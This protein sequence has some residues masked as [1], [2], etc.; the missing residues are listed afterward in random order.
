MLRGDGSSATFDS[1]FVPIGTV[2]IRPA[3]QRR[4]AQIFQPRPVGTPELAGIQA[5]LQDA[6][7][8]AAFPG[9]KLPR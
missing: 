4:V 9:S 5:S 3:F 7:L 1:F 2:E 6:D 8:F